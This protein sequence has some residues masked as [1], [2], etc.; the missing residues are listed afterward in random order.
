MGIHVLDSRTIDRIAAGEVVERPASVVKELVENAIDAGST[1]IT[2]E[3]KEGGIEFIRVTDNGCGIE[4]E[5]LPTAFL[6]HATSKIED[7]DD[8]NHIASLGFRGEALSSIAA[9]SRVEIITKRKENLTGTRMVLEGA[10]EQSIDEIGAPDGT[11]FLMRNLFFNTPVRRK[12]LKQPATEGSYITDLMEHLALSRP[13]ISFKFVLG[14]QTRFHTSGNGDLREVIYRIYGREIVAQLVPIQMEENG[15]KVEGYL[16]KPVLVRSNR[17][18]EIY[19]INGRFI[20]SGVIAKAIEEGYKQYLMQHKFPLC[21]LHITMDAE[22]VDVNVHPSKM[23]VRFSDGMAFARMLSENIATTLRNREMIPDA[24]LEDEKS[25]QKKEQE[26]RKASWKEHTPEVFEKK[27]EESYRVMEAAKYEAVP[28]DRREFI[29]KPIWQEA[30]AGIQ[31]SIRKPESISARTEEPNPVTAA[32][33]ETKEDDFFVEA[34]PLEPRAETSSEPVICPETA[35]VIEPK[36]DSPAQAQPEDKEPE[37]KAVQQMNLFEEK[38]LSVQNR[39]R[40][41]IIGQVF[42]TYW[43]IQFEDKL[44]IIDQHA[45]HEKVKYERLMKQFHEKSVISQ[46]LMPPIIVSLT[47]QEESI[48]HTYEDAF[49]QLGFEIEAFGGNE[50]ALRSVPVDLYGCSERELF[51]AVLDELSQETG[52]RGSFQVIEEKIASMSC[53]AAVKG[54]NRLSLQEADQLIDELL[55]L[56][57][58]YNCPHG[59]PTIIA[60]TETDLEKKF[61]RIV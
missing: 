12:F 21:V 45:A 9:V 55:T 34:A 54:N 29:Q 57:N 25:I 3:A 17:N 30:H 11:T 48:L 1:A 40:Y 35:E 16:G 49:S 61:K 28:K 4:R 15:I 6:R 36:E 58:P 22:T 26:D 50:Y 41:R 13:D 23:D 20:R 47:G 19:F 43:L 10:K 51:L 59:R 32:T 31:T 42:D 38:L 24:S 2:V 53:K 7:A 5:Q 52:N 14:N 56:D 27:R 18:F 60:M 8:L 39:S 33:P 44:F 37:V 46:R